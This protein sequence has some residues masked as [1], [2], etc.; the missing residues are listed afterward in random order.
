MQIFRSQRK[1]TQNIFWRWDDDPKTSNKV[2]SDF[3]D[4]NDHCIIFDSWFDQSAELP[5]N[6]S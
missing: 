4:I 3:H 5:G 6:E 1:V 2:Y